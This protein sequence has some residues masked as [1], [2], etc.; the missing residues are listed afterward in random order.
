MMWIIKNTTI[1]SLI[2]ILVGATLTS[3]AD[4][5][6]YRKDRPLGDVVKIEQ[7]VAEFERALQKEIQLPKYI[8]FEI[9]Y[10][11]AKYNPKNK[12][13]LISYLN[14]KTGALMD[15]HVKQ[16]EM[17][18]QLTSRQRKI[19]MNVEDKVGIYDS[20]DKRA[21]NFVYFYSKGLEYR[22]AINKRPVEYKQDTFIK[23]AESFY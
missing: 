12:S 8:P 11:G 6:E 21:V 10:S 1:I 3:N 13:I 16:G 22:V 14:E 20:E 19:K 9:T 7:A 4:P 18:S 17:P 2:A 23:V 5:L 15:V